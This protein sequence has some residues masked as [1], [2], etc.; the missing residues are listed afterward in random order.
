M[1][2]Q[3]SRLRR[4]IVFKTVFQSEMMLTKYQE[5]TRI[6]IEIFPQKQIL[7]K[8]QNQGVIAVPVLGTLWM[9]ENETKRND[10]VLVV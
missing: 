10:G 6:R 4:A 3:N 8:Y 1:V 9:R 2:D 5:A 7:A